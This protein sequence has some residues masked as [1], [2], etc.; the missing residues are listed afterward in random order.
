MPRTRVYLP[1]TGADLTTLQRERSLPGP[2]PACA[3]TRALEQS[4]KGA[5][6]EELEYLA[7]QQ[8]AQGAVSAAAEAGEPVVVAA[9]DVE[10]EDVDGVDMPAAKLPAGRLACS[11]TVSAPVRLARVASF[12]LGDGIAEVP[13]SEAAVSG[14]AVSGAAV[15]G[16]DSDTVQE[17]EER[18]LSWYDVT[19]LP[20]LVDLVT[21]G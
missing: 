3:V 10:P 12:H 14:A 20:T 19:E 1:V 2:R 7:L 16:A 5:E 8:A 17:I 9:A 6:E 15:S 11:V 21:R 18:E 13:D 4:Q